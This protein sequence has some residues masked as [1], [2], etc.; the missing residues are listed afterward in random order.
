[1]A[2]A[3]TYGALTTL[4]NE[5]MLDVQALKPR[6]L[7]RMTASEKDAL[8]L[9]LLSHIGEQSKAIEA[10][11][12]HIERQDKVLMLRFTKFASGAHEPC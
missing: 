3:P 4:H 5:P 10:K 11:Q 9:Q 7:K 1:M 2:N 8:M 12:V 6:D